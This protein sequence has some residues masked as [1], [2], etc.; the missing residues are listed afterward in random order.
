MLNHFGDEFCYVINGEVELS[1]EDKKYIMHKGDC[2][3]YN[4]NTEHYI[5]NLSN[6]ISRIV[7]V[8]T[9]PSI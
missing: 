2:A 8:I 5:K 6:D 4:S 9:P 7:W 3:Y 1:L